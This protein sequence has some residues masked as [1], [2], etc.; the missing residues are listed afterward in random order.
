MH[1]LPKLVGHV[2]LII[3]LIK[4]VHLVGVTNGVLWRI[5]SIHSLTICIGSNVDISFWQLRL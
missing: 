2:P 5:L 1:I 3:L 4:T